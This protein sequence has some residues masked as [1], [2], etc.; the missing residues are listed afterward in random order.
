MSDPV[1]AAARRALSL[2]GLDT[3]GAV[4][5]QQ[6]RADERYTTLRT[7]FDKVSAARDE[8]ARRVRVLTAEL[9]DVRAAGDLA[10]GRDRSDLDYVFVITY[11]RSGS[12]LLQGILSSDPGITIRGENG[13][14]LPRLFELHDATAAHR[15][16]MLRPGPLPPHH[17]WWGIDGYRDETAFRAIRTLMLETV[18]RPEPTTEVVGFKDIVWLPE[19]LPE[20]LDFTRRVFP[21]ARFVLNTR[22]LEQVAR[23]RWWQ[24]RE[25]P[26]GELRTLEERYVAA[27]DGVGDVAY[28]V[29]YDDYVADPTV[30][31]GLFSWLGRD[32]DE[33]RVRAVMAVEHSY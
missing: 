6:A 5:H 7:R 33:D 31:R 10:A 21:G 2:F 15:E 22:N 14:M 26:M 27:V 28:R 30:L 3:A 11:G 19:R 4:R 1:R 13:G 29:H 23:S 16:R 25:D 8:L 18:L 17:P 9:D 12:T 24:H 20:L 32:F